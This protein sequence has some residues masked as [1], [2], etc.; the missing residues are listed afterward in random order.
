MKTNNFYTEICNAKEFSEE[1]EICIK[2]NKDYKKVRACINHAMK[3][4][5]MSYNNSTEIFHR[6]I[7]EQLKSKGL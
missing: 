4:D 2:Y 7:I 5:M 1:K 6:R 3:I